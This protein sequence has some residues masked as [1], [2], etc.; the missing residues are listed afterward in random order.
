MA[1]RFQKAAAFLTVFFFT[2]SQ[3]AWPEPSV[4]IDFN[5]AVQPV[6]EVL[7]D[8]SA[9]DQESIPQ[10]SIDFL[11]DHSPLSAAS[12]EEDK[13]PLIILNEAQDD[14][15]LQIIRTK[16]TTNKKGQVT[17]FQEEIRDSEGNLLYTVKRTSIR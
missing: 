6:S 9:E 1:K 5:K 17:G 16:T 12:V 4:P 11:A 10:T 14:P 7:Q 2:A 8:A 3:I 15:P 13:Q